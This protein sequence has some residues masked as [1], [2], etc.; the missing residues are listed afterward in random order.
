MEYIEGE[1][2]SNKIKD[3]KIKDREEI[4]NIA[5]QCL[6]GLSFAHSRGLLHKNLKPGNCFL[7]N[8]GEVKI[9]DFAIPS[10]PG[11]FTQQELTLPGKDIMEDTMILEGGIIGTPAYMAPELW[12]KNFG[13]G[14]PWTDIYS[15]GIMLFEL[16]CG[17]NPFD[18]AKDDCEELK[19]CHQEVEPEDPSEVNSEIPESISE[20]I[21]KCIQKGPEDRFQNCLEAMEE[22]LQVYEILFGFPYTGHSLK[23]EELTLA[24]LN[25]RALSLVDLG[26]IDDSIELWDKGLDLD[27]N[28]IYLNFNKGLV[29]WH[30]GKIDD[31]GLLNEFQSILVDRP[32]DWR[33]YYCMGNIHMERDDIKSAIESF[34]KVV[35]YSPDNEHIRILIKKLRECLSEFTC[36]IKTI[37][38]GSTLTQVY[39]MSDDKRRALVNYY[40]LKKL[41]ISSG[42]WVEICEG[43]SVTAGDVNFD[44]TM[45]LTGHTNGMLKLWDMEGGEHLKTFFIL[46]KDNIMAVAL[47]PDGC[48]ALSGGS[49]Q[50]ICL[51]DVL[52]KKCI[53][54]L[55]GHMSDIIA[56]QFS[57]DSKSFF[58][59][60]NDGM[61]KVWDVSS[62]ECIKSIT[63]KKKFDGICFSG[64]GKK[65]AVFDNSPM[66]AGDDKGNPEIHIW[67]IDKGE[68]IKSFQYHK[69]EK[70]SSMDL[71]DDGTWLLAGDLCKDIKLY[72]SYTGQCMRTLEGHDRGIVSLHL[73]KDTTMAL[74]C[75]FRGKINIWSINTAGFD[76]SFGPALSR[77]K[78]V[79]SVMEKK[80][81]RNFSIIQ[82]A[83]EEKQ[84]HKALQL[85]RETGEQTGYDMTPK[86]LKFWRDI[87]S[88]SRK[89]SL[90]SAKLIR[91]FEGHEDQITSVRMSNNGEWAVSG[92]RDG[93][94][95]VW[96]ILTGK[97]LKVLE[98]EPVGVNSL[99]ISNDSRYILAGYGDSTLRFWEIDT[100][101]CLKTIK[102][103]D[104]EIFSVYLSSDNL[105]AVAGFYNKIKIWHIDTGYCIR[106]IEEHR[107]K[108]LSVRLNY[109]GR[110]MISGVFPI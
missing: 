34:E 69:K 52:T 88:Y 76:F 92:S 8:C 22:L 35:E 7:N 82:K 100:E 54:K 12:D 28:N 72:D 46:P 43:S 97:A 47:S 108:I 56:L 58:S 26:L 98:D 107:G 55:P 105:W 96:D 78:P 37:D 32:E 3:G 57:L 20:F 29:K 44:G 11:I 104:G 71:N 9:S 19:F 15:L 99:C 10:E 17:K 86:F 45:A 75:D 5:I 31:T 109:D 89:T 59:A 13:E 23:E 18:E 73:N 102:N 81:D 60:S 70:I 49:R 27:R 62:T 65:T 83:I 93:T 38:T 40:E 6:S 90:K 33:I 36:C 67:D 41:E 110:Y 103:T 95:R 50:Y 53:T 64:D 87:Y 94:I 51:W 79:R 61:V 66:I 25:S 1:K 42:E 24:G 4:L 85:L 14:G 16:F 74:S 63:I 68:C 80:I 21:L 39:S 106:T 48:K 2:L 77:L 101:K 91:I 30:S 84:W